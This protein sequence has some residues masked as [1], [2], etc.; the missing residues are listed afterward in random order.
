[1]VGVGSRPGP[2]RMNSG[3]TGAHRQPWHR[4]KAKVADQL[5][6][7]VRRRP[8]HHLIRRAFL[9]QLTAVQ[10]REPVGEGLRVRELVRDQYGG[11]PTCGHQP[12]DQVRQRAAQAGVQAGERLVEQQGVAG[13]KQQA[14]ERHSVP[15]SARQPGRHGAQQP[16][17]AQHA[18]HLGQLRLTGRASVGQVGPH[19]Q[20]R[21]QGGV[22]AQ[23]A[24][25]PFPRGHRAH[26]R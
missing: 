21:E 15:L 17:Q 26:R 8:Q 25:P 10:D 3:Q 19:G 1:M 18:G 23:Q 5:R 16:A 12:G 24:D 13:R 20:V 4:H 11:H 2:V 6:R 14:A 22:L 7:P 9:Q